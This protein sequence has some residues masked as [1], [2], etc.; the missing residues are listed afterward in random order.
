M[1][2]YE[3][4]QEAFRKFVKE[5]ER[6]MNF[7]WLLRSKFYT[8]DELEKEATRQMKREDILKRVF[9]SLWAIDADFC[10]RNPRL[11]AYAYAVEL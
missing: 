10:I 1:K 11:A 8:L 9:D 3:S 2:T 6:N 5:D 4:Y 7:A